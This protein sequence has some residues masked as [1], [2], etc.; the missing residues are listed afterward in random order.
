MKKLRY[1]LV[2]LFMTAFIRAAPAQSIPLEQLLK[3][4]ALPSGLPLKKMTAAL[5]P[6]GWTYQ[7]LVEHTQETYWTANDTE[8]EF[9]NETEAATAWV[10]LRPMP[11]GTVDVLFK[12]VSAKSFDPIRRDL[13]HRKLPATPV[14][15]L[16]CVG[17]RYEASTYTVTLY[18]GKKGPYP[19]IVVLHQTSTPAAAAPPSTP[20]PGTEKSAATAAN[21]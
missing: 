6:P 11:S 15:C 18:S 10:S 4:G 16:E 3:L 13:K 9:D 21:P 8:Y 7:G 17:E 14:T 19:Y 2:P 1:L 12:T 5:F 20:A